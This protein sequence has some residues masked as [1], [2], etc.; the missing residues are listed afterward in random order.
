MPLRSDLDQTKT[1][2]KGALPASIFD[3]IEQSIAELGT[4]GLADRAVGLGTIPHLPTLETI[5]GHSLDLAAATA[6]KP[7]VLLFTRGGWCPYCNTTLRAYV[8][9]FPEIDALGGTLIALTPELPEQ[10]AVAARDNELPFTLAVDRGNTFARSLGLVFAQPHDLRP[11]FAEIGINLPA[12]NGDESHE[13]P[14][15]AIFVLDRDGRVVF[16][17]VAADFTS[18]AEPDDVLAA[19]RDVIAQPKAA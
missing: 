15:P 9:A 5:G 16:A 4:T 6:G 19:L 11:R 8:K 10:A 7:S 2:V 12:R 1:A 17:H 3:R 18:R 14:I 13:L